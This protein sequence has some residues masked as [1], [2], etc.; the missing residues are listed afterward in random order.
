MNLAGVS[1]VVDGAPVGVAVVGG[2]VEGSVLVLPDGREWVMHLN[3]HNYQDRARRKRKIM[4]EMKKKR[5]DGVGGKCTTKPTRGYTL[6]EQVWN[7]LFFDRL[8]VR[9]RRQRYLNPIS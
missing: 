1:A 7:N 5:V 2:A 8:F 3:W 4:Q 9:Y 6:G